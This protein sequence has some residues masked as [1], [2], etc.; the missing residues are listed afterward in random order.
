MNKRSIPTGCQTLRRK[1][2]HL[3]NGKIYSQ[4]KQKQSGKQ[5]ATVLIV[6]RTGRRLLLENATIEEIR[7]ILES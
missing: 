5:I 6:G 1:K 2:K 3:C 7:Q 4:Y